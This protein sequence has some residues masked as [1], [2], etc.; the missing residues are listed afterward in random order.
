MR[1]VDGVH[2]PQEEIER[3]QSRVKWLEDRLWCQDCEVPMGASMFSDRDIIRLIRNGRIKITPTPNISNLDGD[4][5]TCKLDFHLGREALIPDST[6][7]THLDLSE[8]VPEE[9]FIK[10]DIQKRGK[11]VIAPGALVIASTLERLALADDLYARM[12][13]KSSVARKGGAVQLAALFDAGWDGYPMMELHNIT[14]TPLIARFGNSICA[15][16]FGH[17]SSLALKGYTKRGGV[18]YKVQEKVQV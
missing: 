14:S 18:H 5:G 3:L 17:L 7:I 16:S 15:F 11:I 2:A 4:L 9:Y 1:E 13:G 12:E 10:F 8:P 6:K